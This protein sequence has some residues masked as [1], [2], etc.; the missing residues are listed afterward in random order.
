[1]RAQCPVR[2]GGHIIG[3][4]E[5]TAPI[6]LDIAG[7]FQ[8]IETYNRQWTQLKKGL[9]QTKLLYTLVMILIGLFALFV[10]TWIAVFLAKQISVPISAILNGF[11]EVRRGNLKHRVEVPA[12]DELALLVRGFNQMTQ[13]LESSSRELDRRRRFTEA[14]LESIPTGVISIGADGYIKRVNQALSKIL[15]AATV[16]RATRLEDLFSRE[17]TAEIKYL[18]KRARRTGTAV[19]PDG[20]AHR[21]PQTA[22][23]GDG[24]RARGTAHLGICPGAGRHQRAAAGAEG[25]GLARSGAAGGARDQESADADRAFG[26]ADRAPDRAAGPAAAATRAFCTSAR[27]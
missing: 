9:V 3:R 1:M 19:A 17:D 22:T 4:A 5:L 21:E 12:V 15:P 13:D 11:G 24:L 25:R 6:P 14:I 10:T 26:G 18:M 7:Q 20:V 16:E 2:D 27:G 23:C 8:Q